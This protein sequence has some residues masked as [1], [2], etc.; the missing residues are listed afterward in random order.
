MDDK[1]FT[2]WMCHHFNY[3]EK[4]RGHK[5]VPMEEAYRR[6]RMEYRE[7]KDLLKNIQEMVD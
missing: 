7:N 1:Q 3:S 2:C 6:L 5:V 4:H